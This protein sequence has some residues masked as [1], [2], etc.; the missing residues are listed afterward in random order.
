MFLSKNSQY[1]SFCCSN[2]STLIPTKSP[3]NMPVLDLDGDERIPIH[4]SAIGKAPERSD[5][6]VDLI[7]NV[8]DSILERIC[9]RFFVLKNKKLSKSDCCFAAQN[10]AKSSSSTTKNSDCNQFDEAAQILIDL[11]RQSVAVLYPGQKT[12]PIHRKNILT[13]A[14]RISAGQALTAQ[15]LNSTKMEFAGT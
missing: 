5:I 10:L 11:N 8:I 12:N 9:M 2:T 7:S 13:E 1:D 6:E 3:T 4:P 15:L 14:F